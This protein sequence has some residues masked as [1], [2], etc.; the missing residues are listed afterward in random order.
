MIPVAILAGGLATRLRP[1]TE[2]IPKSLIDIDGKP[3]IWH[4]LK[5][6]KEKGIDHVVIC[7]GYLGE[8][9]EKYVR[10]NPDPQLKVDFS[11]DGAVLLG[12]GGAIKKALPLLGE[13]FFVMYGDSYFDIDGVSFG[14]SVFLIINLPP[15][16]FTVSIYIL[17]NFLCSIYKKYNI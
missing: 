8:K 12:T 4:Q 6:L 3:F 17:S 11:Y 14:L 9:I 5:L 2:T 10:E 15:T 13:E 7:C 16:L 1:V